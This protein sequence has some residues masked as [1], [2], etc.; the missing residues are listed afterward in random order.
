M[1]QA[2]INT[3][4]TYTP[5]PLWLL[6]MAQRAGLVVMVGLPWEQ[7]ITFLDDRRRRRSIRATLRK[8]VRESSGHPA[9]FCYAIGNEIPSPIVRWHGRRRVERFLETL[10][11]ET[12]EE[13]PDCLATYVNYPTTEYLQLPFSDIYCFNV[14]LEDP[15]RLRSY[16]GRLQNAAGDRPLILTELGLDS[17]THGLERQAA[18]VESQLRATFECGCAGAFVFK[19]T[20]EWYRGGYD[21]EDW[22]FGLTDRKRSLKPAYFAARK[23]YT[24]VPPAAEDRL[25]GISVAVCAYNAASTLRECLQGALELEYP[26]FEVIVVDDGSTDD[27][28]AIAREYGVRLASTANRGLSAARNTAIEMATGEIVAYLDSDAY[29]DRE[30]LT[31]LARA[32]LWSEHVGVGGPNIV[33]LDAGT[34][35]RC[36]ANAPGGPNHV[37][38][39]DTEAEH[40]P[41]CNMAFRKKAL[42][43]IGGFDPLFRIAGDDVDAC[44]RLQDNGG[45]LGFSPGAM[46]WHHRRGSVKGYLKQQLNY[47]RAEA[48]LERKWPQRHSRFGHPDWTGRLYGSGATDG[49]RLRRWHVYQGVWGTAP[50]QGLYGMPRGTLP[51]LPSM[52]EWYLAIAGL[53]VLSSLGLLWTPILV[54]LPL[55]L[56]TLVA[57]LAQA[58][59]GALRARHEC[60]PGMRVQRI[61]D[62]LLVAALHLLQPAV[63]LWGRLSNSSALW[64]PRLGG[65]KVPRWRSL[66]HWSETWRAVDRWLSVLESK[67]RLSRAVVRRG[68][69]FDRWDLEVWYRLFGGVR[70]RAVVEE[71][72]GGK[73]LVRIRVWPRVSRLSALSAAVFAALAV[74]AGFAGAWLVC[75]ALATWCVALFARMASECGSTLSL[76][77]RSVEAWSELADEES[78]TTREEESSESLVATQAAADLAG[79]NA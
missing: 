76:V 4:R 40:I 68:G 17:R 60:P 16:I 25:P 44:W 71:H 59:L 79:T 72:G 61:R 39:T 47:G 8:G 73:Q 69:D 27:T 78:D 52:P 24:G 34:V 2:G 12:K 14:F 42:E 6:D 62:G 13:A 77:E 31:H 1:A 35:E 10:Y 3:L 18:S 30:W 11:R 58:S 29:P 65:W 19:W 20:D 33:P 63:R 55:F 51:L 5:P 70:L 32:F 41:G 49:I 26:D 23:V 57:P 48:M 54:A 67:L 64:P 21:I 37:L 28:A 56:L 36:V 45:T 50:F 43:E 66:S 7:H 74:A 9:V 38:L 22:D 53:G 46:V 75:G 15:A